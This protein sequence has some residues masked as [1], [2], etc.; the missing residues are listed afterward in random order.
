MAKNKKARK[1]GRKTKK[2]EKKGEEQKSEKNGRRQ[3]KAPA[4]VLNSEL[5]G[6]VSHQ[7][8]AGSSFLL[9]GHFSGRID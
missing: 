5:K 3:N 8:F 6:L 7:E 4:T 9:P 1:K 2:R